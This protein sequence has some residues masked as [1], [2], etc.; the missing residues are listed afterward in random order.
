M[1]Y[2]TILWC[3]GNT[4]THWWRCVQREMRTGVLRFIF[5]LKI[6]QFIYKYINE[7][8]GTGFRLI[9]KWLTR[10][11]VTK[12]LIT[13]QEKQKRQV[14]YKLFIKNIIFEL[15]VS[16]TNMYCLLC[17]MQSHKMTKLNKIIFDLGPEERKILMEKFQKDESGEWKNTIDPI[18]VSF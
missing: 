5:N 11:Q 2:Y 4:S 18:W 17:I 6:W 9:K 16:L 15:Y 3:V 1:A 14:L 7:W 8:Y 13:H 10:D 12:I